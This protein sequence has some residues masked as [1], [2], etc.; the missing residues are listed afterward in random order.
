MANARRE[1]SRLRALLGFLRRLLSNRP[2]GDKP[3]QQPGD[4]FANRMA[5]VRRG[6]KGRSGAAAVAEP[7]EDTYRA[8]PPRG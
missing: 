5:P 2:L 8:F 1:R 7:E 4:P 3:P 6:P